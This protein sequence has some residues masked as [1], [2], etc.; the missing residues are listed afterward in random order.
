ML[1]FPSEPSL[2]VMILGAGFSKSL[3]SL[4]PLT[5]DLG[6]RVL[7]VVTAK[8]EHP[9]IRLPFENGRFEAWLS[10]ISDD[11]PDLS[12]AE[13]LANR[14]LFELCSESLASVLDGCVAEAKDEA[15]SHDWLMEFLGTLHARQ[16][17]VITFN[18]DT[19]IEIAVGEA[20]MYAWKQSRWRLDRPQ[21]KIEWWD[22]LDG[23]PSLPPNRYGFEIPQPTFRLLKL[24]GSTNWFW[25][26]GDHSG[27]TTSSWLLPGTMNPAEAVPDEEAARRRALPGRV[28]LIV[29]PSATKSSYYR[30]PLLT[31]LWQDARKALSQTSVRVALIGYSIPTTDL[32]TTG[33]LRET[34]VERPQHESVIVDV[35]NPRPRPVIRNL[36][37]LGIKGDHISEVRAIEAYVTNFVARAASEVVEAFRRSTDDRANS[38]VLTGN[39]IAESRKVVGFGNLRNGDLELNVEDGVPPYVGTNIAAVGKPPAI[40]LRQL[41]G[42]LGDPAVERFVVLTSEG[43]RRSVVGATP[44]VRET[45]AGDGTWQFLI[46]ARSVA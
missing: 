20:E 8:A 45:G 38:L 7:A 16:S 37:L 30:T 36:R 27:A 15:L 9:A 25:R 31:Q 4:M 17:T 35:V 34:V 23:Q 43:Q 5:D 42:A 12:V 19:L 41:F 28:P 44:Y 13:N 24:H 1:T 14:V 2:E 21:P 10:R 18:Q 6:N 40:S 3:S 32:V 46:T 29:P 39:S 11:Q 26:N 22:C 33:M